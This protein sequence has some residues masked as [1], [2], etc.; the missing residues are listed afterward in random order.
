MAGYAAGE[1]GDPIPFSNAFYDVGGSADLGDLTATPYPLPVVAGE[2]TSYDA[3]WTGL[4]PGRYFGLFGSSG[5]SSTTLLE[6]NA[7]P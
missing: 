3:S 6:V 7:A 4:D 5:S 2:E 1:Q